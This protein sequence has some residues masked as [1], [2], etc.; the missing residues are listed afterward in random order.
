MTA[1]SAILAVGIDPELRFPALRLV[2]EAPDPE[3]LVAV[4]APVLELNFKL[5]PVL[6]GWLPV[7]ALE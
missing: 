3:K 5:V 4:K 7:A 6:G 1:S 2:R